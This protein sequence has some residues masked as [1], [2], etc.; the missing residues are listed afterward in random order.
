MDALKTSI[1]MRNI[2]MV[3][4][5][6][7]PETP[8]P[9]GLPAATELSG[10]LDALMPYGTESSICSVSELDRVMTL[11]EADQKKFAS[12]TQEQ[13]DYIF[14]EVAREANMS[15]VQLAQYAVEDTKRG[16]VSTPAATCLPYPSLLPPLAT[17]RARS[18]YL[19]AFS[20][21]TLTVGTGSCAV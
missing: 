7:V 3:P 15:R 11:M 13:V 2:H 8:R 19:R 16:V 5:L 14:Q 1:E 21:Y 9:S 6:A 17:F 4:P 12:Y 10:E 18:F 20:Y